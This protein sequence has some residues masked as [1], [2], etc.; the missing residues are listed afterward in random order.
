MSII[1]GRFVQ[2]LGKQWV[3]YA[4]PFALFLLLTESARF[5]PL[6]SPYLYI[7]K[8]IIVGILLWVWRHRYASDFKGSL[9]WREWM[10]AICCGLLVL[11]IWVVSEK[12]LFQFD[13][14]SWF[15]PYAL[16]GTKVAAFGLISIRLIGSSIVVP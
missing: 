5:F 6:L 15:D 11:V 1:R 10:T 9:S 4:F 7:A 16:G 12:Y 3:P 13:K 14:D 8:T 2:L